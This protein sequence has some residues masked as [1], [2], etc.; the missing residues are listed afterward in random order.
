MLFHLVVFL[1]EMGEEH[2]KMSCI[3][4]SHLACEYRCTLPAALNAWYWRGVTCAPC[5]QSTT[6]LGALLML[7]LFFSRLCVFA[8]MDEHCA[9]MRH[10]SPY[11]KYTPA[12]VSFSVAVILD[13][14]NYTVCTSLRHRHTANQKAQH[15]LL[16]FTRRSD[17]FRFLSLPGESGFGLRLGEDV[18]DLNS[19]VDLTSEEKG[20]LFL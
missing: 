19:M 20:D 16:V 4:D 9:A 2:F 3:M 12:V 7:A 14:M 5:L 8:P 18:D 6:T 10:T 17:R 1:R 13:R 15:V 11:T